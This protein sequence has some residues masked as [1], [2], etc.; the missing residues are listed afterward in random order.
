MELFERRHYFF[1]RHCGSFQFLDAPAVDG[2]RVLAGRDDG[3]PCPVCGSPLA[4]ATLDR[5][6]PVD[7][8]QQ[9]RGVLLAR[10][11]FADVIRT[12]RA[13]AGGAP[14]EPPP[15]DRRELQRVV[16]CPSCR[17]HMDVHPY[18]GPGNVVIDTCSACDLV[19]LDF[20]EL[21]QIVEA[22]GRDRGKGDPDPEPPSR[23]DT[24][25]RPRMASPRRIS[26]QD[27][28][29]LFD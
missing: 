26:L 13:W 1:C 8:C 9:C 21:T 5:A 14:F 18:Y 19:W 28:F 7:Y 16:T 20:G 6:A 3:R 17:R 27:L 24:D 11:S 23:E 2:L 12:R 22:P 10:R 4:K 15:L 29:E 25:D